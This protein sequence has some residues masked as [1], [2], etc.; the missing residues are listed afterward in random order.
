MKRAE[1]DIVKV[2]KVFWLVFWLV[3]GIL[4]GTLL[5]SACGQL[6]YLQWLT[7]GQTISFS[8]AADLII[9]TFDL[10]LHFTLNMAQ[11]IG[12]LISVLCYRKFRF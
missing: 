2:S 9:F 11:V 6:P 3:T 1:E 10:D 5:G 12:V 8:P 4:I 7:Q